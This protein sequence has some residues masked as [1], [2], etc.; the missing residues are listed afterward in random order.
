[1][2]P[3]GAMEQRA[4][5]TDAV[6][7][8]TGRR[9]GEPISS[10]QGNQRISYLDILGDGD[11]VVRLPANIDSKASRLQVFVADQALGSALATVGTT[12]RHSWACVIAAAGSTMPY[13]AQRLN[14]RWSLL[15]WGH[16]P[17]QGHSTTAIHPTV[18]HRVGNSL[19]RYS[20][21]TRSSWKPM[22][23]SGVLS[24]SRVLTIS[25]LSVSAWISARQDSADCV[26][27][28]AVFASSTSTG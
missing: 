19:R 24:P 12:L 10:F 17:V 5:C 1:M 6:T 7:P 21:R 9:H 25:R 22:A 20:L 15:V 27:I 8:K 28:V 16:M 23:R 11:I 14:F 18:E 4:T 13:P 2:Q 3:I 26:S